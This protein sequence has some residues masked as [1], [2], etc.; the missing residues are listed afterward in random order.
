MFIVYGNA[1]CKIYVHFKETDASVSSILKDEECNQ[2]VFWTMS[3]MC[4]LA[5]IYEIFRN[6]TLSLNVILQLC[7]GILGLLIFD[8]TTWI[9]YIFVTIV[10]VSIIL[11]M[12]YHSVKT[13]HFILISMF[14]LEWILSI[15]TMVHHSQMLN[16]EIY[17]LINFALFYTLEHLLYPRKG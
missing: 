11:F 1:I 14:H 13:N 17:L 10:F 8:F 9:H 3:L 7:I 6:D 15:L 4:I 5:V 2:Y 12:Y 16:Y